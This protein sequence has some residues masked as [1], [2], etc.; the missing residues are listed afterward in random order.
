MFPQ[1]STRLRSGEIINVAFALIVLVSLF[2]AISTMSNMGVVEITALLFLTTF[3]ILMG[4]YGF[5]RIL[6]SSNPQM[7]YFY[8]FIQGLLGFMIIWLEKGSGFQALIFLPLVGQFV[9]LF[10]GFWIF[11]GNFFV[12]GMYSIATFLLFGSIDIVISNVLTFFAGQIFVIVFTQMAV[13]EEKARIKAE[14][15]AQELTKA[16]QQLKDYANQV[17]ELAIEKERTRLAREIHDGIGHSLTTVFMQLQAALAIY[18]KEPQKAEKI[19]L[20]AQGLTKEALNDVRNS[21][22]ELRDSDVSE[23]SL[24]SR[25]KR[26]ASNLNTIG[27]VYTFRTLGK[28]RELPVQVKKA[29][30]RISQEG[31]NNAI[32]HANASKVA[33]TLDYRERKKI[34][35]ILKDNGVGRDDIKSGY[36]LIGIEERMKL[37][38]GSASFIS[39][40]GQGFELKIEVPG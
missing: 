3:Y 30:Y 40:K 33:I 11:V 32:K 7:K 12:L 35:L 17:E 21:I 10:E 14:D 26:L 31:I 25:I 9:L 38:K 8:P 1:I 24:S 5:N 39:K 27:L 4:I 23:G 28:S 37:L 18:H 22:S 6:H 36:G 29:L 19:I 20:S 15:L 34:T 13:D 2:S 16:N